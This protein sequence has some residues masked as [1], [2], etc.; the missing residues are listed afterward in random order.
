MQWKSYEHRIH[1]AGI[2]EY[3]AVPFE[4]KAAEGAQRAFIEGIKHGIK[5]RRVQKQ[6]N[7]YQIYI[8][9]R[10]F[11]V[12]HD[13]SPLWAGL[14]LFAAAGICNRRYKHADNY[15]QHQHNRQRGAYAPC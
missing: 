6:Q 10:L 14:L 7:Q 4:C 3:I 1:Y 2:G 11:A 8:L 15:K 13:S 12:T 5:D 9:K